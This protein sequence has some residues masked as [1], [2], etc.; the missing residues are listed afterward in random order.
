MFTEKE[1]FNEKGGGGLNKSEKKAFKLL[2]YRKQTQ[3]LKVTR[4]LREQQLDKI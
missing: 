2:L 1:R 4:K 3:E